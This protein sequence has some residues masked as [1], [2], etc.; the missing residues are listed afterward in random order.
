[1]RIKNCTCGSGL[2]RE[3]QLDGYGIFL[4]YTCPKCER[5]KMSRWRPDIHTLYAALE[6]I[7]AED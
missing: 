5:A 1:M 7:E 4:C 6:P 3:E 2:P